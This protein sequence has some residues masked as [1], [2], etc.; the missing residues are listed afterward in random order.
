M[1]K[2]E[3]SRIILDDKQKQIIE[4]EGKYYISCFNFKEKENLDA[5]FNHPKVKVIQSAFQ[6]VEKEDVYHATVKDFTS[7]EQAEE[8]LEKEYPVW[9]KL[10][11]LP[12]S[13]I[14]NATFQKDWFE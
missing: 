8:S 9:Y 7:L 14:N 6:I 11:F 5:F 1:T 2:N 3:I 4:K 13:Y 12:F 10:A